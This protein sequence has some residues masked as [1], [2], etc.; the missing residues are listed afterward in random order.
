MKESKRIWNSETSVSEELGETIELDALSSVVGGR[1]ENLN[2]DSDAFAIGGVPEADSWNRNANVW[3]G[4]G[5]PEADQWN[6]NANV[7]T[8]GGVPEADQWNRNGNVWTAGGR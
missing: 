6:R 4:G 5:V 1:S 7:W 2:R 8:G 3:T